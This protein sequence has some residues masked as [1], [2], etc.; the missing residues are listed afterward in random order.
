MPCVASGATEIVSPMRLSSTSVEA[1]GGQPGRAI[2]L[3]HGA[4]NSAGVW[5]FWQTA[6]ARH[7]WTT[8]AVDLRGHGA[9]ATDLSAVSMHDYAADVAEFAQSLDA[10]PVVM[11]W[12]M[13]G[14]VAMMAA[15]AGIAAACVGL[16]PST[17][18]RSVDAA[19]PLRT[20]VFG[21]EEYGIASRD[22]NDQPAMP[23]LDL[24]ERNV[25]LASP[26]S[27]SR[28]ARDERKAG[29]VIE[30]LPCPLLIATGTA[31][32]SWPRS[33]LRRTMA[34]SGLHRGRGRVALGAGAQPSRVRCPSA[35]HRL[36]A[37][38]L[39]A[40]DREGS[41]LAVAPMQWRC[42]KGVGPP[43]YDCLRATHTRSSLCSVTGP[44]S[45]SPYSSSTVKPASSSR[46]CIS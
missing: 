25:A 27:E 14:L 13:G 10:P 8:H 1:A 37:G 7:G 15:R 16:A 2:V 39:L 31:D 6:L 43:P 24:D 45:K 35:P 3:V 40:A 38:A 22:P 9:D 46:C 20:G 34:Q 30:S 42:S 19:P 29:I 18:A 4:A 36:V 21:P 23:D 28:L 5:R 32:A 17:P 26:A 41:G 44:P 33:A 12:S 11:G